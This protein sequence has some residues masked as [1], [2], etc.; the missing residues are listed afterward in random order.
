M[1]RELPLMVAHKFLE[2][3]FPHVLRNA[4][5]LVPHFQAHTAMGGVGLDPG[6]TAG[7]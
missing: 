1:G 6:V 7:G 3:L 5:P 2:D 4:L